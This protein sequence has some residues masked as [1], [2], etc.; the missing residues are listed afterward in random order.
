MLLCTNFAS[1]QEVE[2]EPDKKKTFFKNIFEKVKSSVT[3]SSQDTSTK[4]ADL[5]TKSV[6]PLFVTRAK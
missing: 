6:V 5:N 2:Q 3:V 1:A 4:T